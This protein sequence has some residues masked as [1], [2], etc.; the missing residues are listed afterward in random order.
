MNMLYSLN[1]CLMGKISIQMKLLHLERVG[2]RTKKIQSKL[3]NIQKKL[4]RLM[5]GGSLQIY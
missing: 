5:A 4:F 1:K 2:C 3:K